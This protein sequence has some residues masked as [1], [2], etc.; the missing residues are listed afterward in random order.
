MLPATGDDVL[1]GEADKAA[2]AARDQPSILFPQQ[3][4]QRHRELADDD[5]RIVR[6]CCLPLVTF[7]DSVTKCASTKAQP[8][9]NRFLSDR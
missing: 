9:E 7:C 6:H 1:S 4:V 2:F 5:F 3:H 8:G